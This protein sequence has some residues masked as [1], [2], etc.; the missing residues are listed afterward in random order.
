MMDDEG[1]K[2]K[3]DKKCQGPQHR[4]KTSNP[5]SVVISNARLIYSVGNQ[6]YYSNLV[7][8]SNNF[9]IFY[10]L[11]PPPPSQPL[12]H[13]IQSSWTVSMKMQNNNKS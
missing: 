5:H 8:V 7:L 1:E 9:I 2:L 3:I 11:H 13:K 4:Q 10:I 6:L 12:T